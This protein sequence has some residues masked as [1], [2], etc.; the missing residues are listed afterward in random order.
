MPLSRKCYHVSGRL[1]DHIFSVGQETTTQAVDA[2]QELHEAIHDQIIPNY[3]N[4][5]NHKKKT[6][7][8]LTVSQKINIL[9]RVPF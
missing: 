4:N 2:K 6:F 9:N 3:N 1:C 7:L 8:L 5:D